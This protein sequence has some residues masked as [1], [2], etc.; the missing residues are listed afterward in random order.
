MQWLGSLICL[1]ALPLCAPASTFTSIPDVPGAF[2]VAGAAKRL[3]VQGRALEGKEVIGL[4]GKPDGYD[5]QVGGVSI[6]SL[7]YA[8]QVGRREP[9]RP[10]PADLSDWSNAPACP[11]D[12]V[13]VDPATGRLRFFAG[14][15]P[16]ALKS[17]VTALRR[18]MYGDSALG[19]WK[20]NRF[21]LSHWSVNLNLWAYDVS[22][23]K[24]P[25]LIGEVSVPTKTYGM[26]TLDSGLLIVGTE[27]GTHCVDVSDPGQMKVVGPLGPSQWFNPITSRYLAGWKSPEETTH[28]Q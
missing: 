26:L 1:A 22:D 18:E 3:E 4:A 7:E 24:A 21:F 6:F 20:G 15:D 16:A 23:P 13:L 17:Q 8:H 10:L 14:H 2:Q 28:F 19:T 12:R 25:R 11:P 9:L 27:R 5:I